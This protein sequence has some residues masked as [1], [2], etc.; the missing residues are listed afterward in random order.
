[1]FR[2]FKNNHGQ[3]MLNYWRELE[4][5]EELGDHIFYVYCSRGSW[6]ED[7]TSIHNH[8]DKLQDV[9]LSFKN[10]GFDIAVVGIVPSAKNKIPKNWKR[11]SETKV[12]AEWLLNDENIK[13]LYLTNIQ[14]F[15]SHNSTMLIKDMYDKIYINQIKDQE[16]KS[17]IF[18]THF[19]ATKRSQFNS[20]SWLAYYFNLD[21]SADTDK[22]KKSVKE[23]SEKYMLLNCLNYKWGGNPQHLKAI[24]DYVN[25]IHEQKG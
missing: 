20:L 8:P 7:D 10:L 11:F 17:L 4:P 25:M 12:I 2:V 14:G 24:Y 16:F 13:K 9:I 1:M 15:G 21:L 5:Q 18:N 3:S 6:S 23:L 19:V 22:I